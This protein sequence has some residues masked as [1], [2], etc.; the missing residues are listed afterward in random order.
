MKQVFTAGGVIAML[1]RNEEDLR[2]KKAN[3]IVDFSV[4]CGLLIAN[5]RFKDLIGVNSSI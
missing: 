3:V 1:G 4:C 2:E 5:S